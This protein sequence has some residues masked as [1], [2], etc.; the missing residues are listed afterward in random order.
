MT[1]IWR[2]QSAGVVC[3]FHCVLVALFHQLFKLC[4]VIAQLGVDIRLSFVVCRLPFLVY[5]KESSQKILT[6]GEYHEF[7]SPEDSISQDQQGCR[8]FGQWGVV[9]GHRSEAHWVH[10]AVVHEYAH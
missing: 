4:W 10:M 8:I 7:A 5:H 1:L 2:L 3:C 6:V 9:L